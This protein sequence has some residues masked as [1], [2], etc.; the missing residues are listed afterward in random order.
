MQLGI[1]SDAL[2]CTF[3]RYSTHL[4]ASRVKANTESAAEAFGVLEEEHLPAFTFKVFHLLVRQE[5]GFRD[6][7]VNLGNLDLQ[8]IDVFK[9]ASI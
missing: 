2:P 1:A 8:V 3:I 7:R 5:P 4:H 6:T 9:Q